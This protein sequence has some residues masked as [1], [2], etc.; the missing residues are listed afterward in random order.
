MGREKV[1]QT[2]TKRLKL[3][4]ILNKFHGDLI[5]C[6]SDDTTADPPVQ[7]NWAP[8]AQKD[9]AMTK[10]LISRVQ[11]NLVSATMEIRSHDQYCIPARPHSRT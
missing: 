4:Q 6:G 11:Q 7:M 10:N 3:L 2:Y 1:T 8:P 5:E 9:S